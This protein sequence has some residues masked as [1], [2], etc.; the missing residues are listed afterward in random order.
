MKI[1]S[2]I[3]KNR[4]S[5]AFIASLC[6]AIFYLL[7]FIDSWPGLRSSGVKGPT[8]FIDQQSI[9]NSANCFSR[10]G[11]NVYKLN[12][13]PSG[14]GGF[15]YSIELLRFL[16]F[17]H[18]TSASS[19][20]LGVA[21]ILITIAIFSAFVYLIRSQG[22]VDNFIALLALS[23]PGIWLLFERG[24]YDSLIYI[25]VVAGLV[26]LKSKFQE[27]GILLI[28]VS[29]LMK[30]YTLPLYLLAILLLKRKVSRIL[31][32]ILS[33]PLMFYILMLIKQVVAFPSTWYVSFG[34]KSL[35]LYFELVTQEK[36]SSKFILNSV[37]ALF[38]G[39][40]FMGLI[41][42]LL[43]RI[44]IKPAFVSE[45]HLANKWANG[46]YF[47]TLVVFLSCFFAGMNFD[48]RLIYPATLIAISSLVLNNNRFKSI[49][50]VSGLVAIWLSTYSFGLH[51]IPALLIQFTA[52]CFL[53]LFTA[54]QLLLIYHRAQP[55]LI[56]L[57]NEYYSSGF[58]G[59]INF[60]RSK[61]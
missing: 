2:D 50:I 19:Y 44:E 55:S 11:A 29:V 12:V 35:G 51:G 43:I 33:I 47:G 9:L 46:I 8:A 56:Q 20:T 21:L 57:I 37:L 10:L 22:K 49:M 6:L 16:N 27:F 32:F 40:V 45:S 48:Y 36:I 53:Y 23:S 1:I 58:I 17:T 42:F 38:I 52:D 54:T 15:Q 24:N 61:F 39:L 41:L 31:A 26:L 18:L 59:L 30:F 28:A 60:L 14:C 5:T 34:L 7:Q 4:N 13:E 3:R 25:L